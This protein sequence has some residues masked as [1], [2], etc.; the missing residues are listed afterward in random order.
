MTWTLRDMIYMAVYVASI[1]GLFTQFKAGLNSVCQ[2]VDELRNAVFLEK[3]GLNVVDNN[4]CM[5]HRDVIHR[6]IRREANLTHE[7]LQQI[8][9]LNQNITK[10][11]VHM[12]IEPISVNPSSN[13]KGSTWNP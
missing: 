12:K 13:D 7:A 6:S 3:G 1:A 10:L 9:C 8:Y 4:Q 11:M 2:R 5:A